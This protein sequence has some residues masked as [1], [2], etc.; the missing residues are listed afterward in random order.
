M[1]IALNAK[2]KI[3]LVAGTLRKPDDNDILVHAWIRCNG[4]VLSW[5]TNSLSKEIAS[6][7]F[8]MITATDVWKDLHERFPQSNLLRFF[9][10]EKLFPH[11]IKKKLSLIIAAL[12]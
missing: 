4:M 3:T 2:N 7:I 8:Y 11:T 10:L 1:S 12:G 9:N 5:P 6:N